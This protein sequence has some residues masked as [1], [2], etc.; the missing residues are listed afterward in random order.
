MEGGGFMER[1]AQQPERGSLA[2]AR[3]MASPIGRIARVLL[4]IALIL[5]GLFAIEGTWGTIIAIIGVIPVAAGIAN[6]CL[7]GPLIGAPFRG[8]DL[9]S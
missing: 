5:I 3:F 1:K 6:V 7:I 8:S 2:F 9:G 4:G